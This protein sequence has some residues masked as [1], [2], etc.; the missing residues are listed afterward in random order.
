[1][2]GVAGAIEPARAAEPDSTR[3]WTLTGSAEVSYTRGANEPDNG[4]VGFRGFDNRLAS[5][6]VANA[7]LD[8]SGRSGAARVRVALQAGLT[9]NTYYAAE[10]THPAEGGAGK[11][12]ADTWR[13]VQQA[14]VGW[15]SPDESWGAD[16]GL[17]LSPVGPEGMNVRDNWNWSR[18]NLFYALPFYHAGLRVRRQLSS[19]LS[20]TGFV[21]NG[22]NNLVDNNDQPSVAGQLAHASSG[23]DA[24]VLYFGGAERTV[25]V[26][27]PWR[28][29]IDGWVQFRPSSNLA[30]MFHADAGTETADLGTDEWIGAAA[31]AHAKLNDN[32][33]LSARLDGI[34]ETQSD[35]AAG[36]VAPIF[37]P[38][39]NDEGRAAAASLT[40]TLEWR[41]AGPL[42]CRLE[43]RHDRAETDLYYDDNAEAIDDGPVVPNADRQTT[44]TFGV[45]AWF[46]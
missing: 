41:P 7:V 28:H 10:P 18:S 4:V 22:W 13:L 38:S 15:R 27:E 42:L 5:F 34:R 1:M 37:F 17:F 23:V 20:A 33:A 21:L 6:S 3:A 36:S 31:Y 24:A 14:W 11:S 32:W 43:A 25:G 29:L 19:T 35:G 30:F 46:E 40:G 9:G 45:T 8:A 44:V 26:E 2:T 16:A 12:D 39:V